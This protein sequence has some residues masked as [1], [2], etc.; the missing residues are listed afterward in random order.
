ML[1]SKASWMHSL[2]AF[3]AVTSKILRRQVS[4][5]WACDLAASA[6]LPMLAGT[7]R[8]V[9]AGTALL[10]DSALEH[11]ALYRSRLKL[12]HVIWPPRGCAS[13]EHRDKEGA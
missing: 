11:P 9:R 5:M 12:G 7:R 1:T 4:E 13:D 10:S 6:L 3:Q 8:L 2:H